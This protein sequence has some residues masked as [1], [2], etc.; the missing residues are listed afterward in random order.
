MEVCR[1]TPQAC[2]LKKDGQVIGR[3]CV[4][5][6]G[7]VECWIDPRWRR[8]GYGTFL[9]KRTLRLLEIPAQMPLTAAAQGGETAFFEKF[10]F[11]PARTGLLVRNRPPQVNA[12]SIAHDFWRENLKPGAFAIDAT[13]GNGHDTELLCRLVGDHGRVLAMDIQ[14][15]A[16][17]TT[18]ERLAAEGL[19]GIG[20]VVQDSHA[21]L[22][23]YAGRGSVDAVVFNLGYLPGGRHDRFTV[24]E[25]SIPAMTAALELLRPGGILTVCAYSGGLQGT[26]ERDAVTLWAAGLDRGRFWAKQEL[27]LQRTGDPPIVVCVRKK[28]QR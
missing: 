1:E 12:L 15:Q 17:E 22:A 8:R 2:V 6:E 26:G 3:A 23:A 7:R 9:L 14:R 19:D 10:G 24:P 25:V 13:A 5:P 20:R 18:R 27:F 16:V 28:T 4:Q 11:A 21:N